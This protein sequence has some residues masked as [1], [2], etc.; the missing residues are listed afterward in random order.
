MLE[1][2]ERDDVARSGQVF[3]HI[4]LVHERRQILAV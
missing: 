1:R 2:H 4:E 3:R